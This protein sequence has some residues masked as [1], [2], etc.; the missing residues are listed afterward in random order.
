MRIYAIVAG[1]M[2]AIIAVLSLIISVPPLDDFN[3]YNPYWNGFSKLSSETDIQY[4]DSIIDERLIAE[5]SRHVLF[6]IGPEREFE[7]V[8]ADFIKSFIENGGITILMDESG[9]GNSLL[10]LLEV[11]PRLN[12]SLLLDP[13]FKDRAAVLPKI[14]IPSMNISEVVANYATTIDGCQKAI[15]Y[16]SFYAFL[17]VNSNSI[18]DEGE[19][20]GP[21]T[22]VCEIAMGKGKLIVISDSSLWINSMISR[23][24]N[25]EFFKRLISNRRCLI[26]RSHWE[27]S[28]FAIVKESLNS[29]LQFFSQLEIRYAFIIG[30]VLVLL[31]LRL[32]KFIKYKESEVDKVLIRNPTWSREVLEK[33]WREMHSER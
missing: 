21:L 11:S 20:R 3:P 12:G 4:L 24:S 27:P 6:I 16:S 17:D 33:L 14:R 10:R 19:P 9:S 15:G 22:V 7:K 25:F 18:W 5:P 28:K 26:D 13:L 8:E 29:F 30:V 32:E 1:F 2:A 31:R 23:G